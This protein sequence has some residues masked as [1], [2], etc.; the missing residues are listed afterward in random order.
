LSIEER[1]ITMQDYEKK[2]FLLL[3]KR[4][5]LALYAALSLLITLIPTWYVYN[6]LF[7]AI[8]LLGV[9]PAVNIVTSKWVVSY[10]E[11]Q[12]YPILAPFATPLKRCRCGPLSSTISGCS[13]SCLFPLLTVSARAII[14][15]YPYSMLVGLSVV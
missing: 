8:A 12:S 6:L 14:T 9:D 11:P 2:A 1:Q 3:S 10:R 7:S 5:K 15:Q 4:T 13:R